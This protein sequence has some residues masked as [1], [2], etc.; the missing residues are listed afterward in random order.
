MSK[1]S[2]ILLFML[3]VLSLTKLQAQSLEQYLPQLDAEKSPAKKADLYYKIG[4]IYQQQG[5]YK[6]ALENYNN[7]LKTDANVNVIAIKQNIISSYSG[8]N[9][10]TSALRAG[11]E[12]ITYYRSRNDTEGLTRQLNE[13]A[14]YAEINR[15]QEDA[16]KY[17]LELADI[18][19]KSN[20]TDKLASIY[21]NLGVTYRRLK[22][23]QT[24]EKY[25]NQYLEILKTQSKNQTNPQ[26][27][28]QTFISIGA[29][30]LELKQYKKATPYFEQALKIAEKTNQAKLRTEAYNFKAMADF[31]NDNTTDALSNATKAKEIAEET[32]DLDNMLKSYEML[33]VIYQKQSD[34]KT[35][36]EY[37]EKIS[38]LNVAIAQ[39]RRE[40]DQRNFDRAIE[41]EKLEKE[42]KNTIAN[43]KIKEG[44]LRETKLEKE[45]AEKE[46]AIKNQQISILKKNREIETAQNRA[47]LN[48]QI[49]RERMS[50]LGRQKAEN[51][52]QKLVIENEKARADQQKAIALNERTGRE[53]KEK[54]LSLAEASAKLKDENQK[55]KDFNQLLILVGGIIIVS[56]IAIA[57]FFVYRNLRITKKLYG[58]LG[59]KNKQ[60]EGQNEEL[61]SQKEELQQNS[62]EIAAQRDAVEAINGKLDEKNTALLASI[63]Y[64]SRIQK[65]ILPTKTKLRTFFA[66]HFVLFQPR[67]IVSGDFYWFAAKEDFCM[68]SASDCTGHG[69]PGALM[70]MIA[71]SSLNKVFYEKRAYSPEKLLSGTSDEIMNALD[72]QNNQG[73]DGMDSVVCAYFPKENR[74]T[75]A[76]A[77]NSLFYVQNDEFFEIRGSKFPV[78]D[79]YYGVH[80]DFTLHEIA[81]T[82]P[83]I[84]YLLSDG[85]CDQFG[86]SEGGK[87][88]KFGK[89]QFK[90][91]IMNIYKKP[92]DVQK[93]TLQI[94]I[95]KWMV[96]GKERQIDDILVVG[97]QVN[98][99]VVTL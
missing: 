87:A 37:Q 54:E 27:Q 11:D 32:K 95:N 44:E 9:D 5:I 67:D 62:E 66:E 15:K 59:E 70:S 84:F 77:K 64:A 30:L 33:K 75:Y 76:G 10:H 98:P 29:T 63:T 31:L 7:A 53:S 79:I 82:A 8:L 55:Q 20:Q 97:F 38:K 26:N 94:T 92:M 65:G 48:E 86:A 85:F 17:N 88:Q 56:L 78:G 34:S 43:Q 28:A 68:I 41:V 13:N 69:V 50:E 42:I 58:K 46:I 74:V 18:Y 93:K 72:Q 60:I 61:Q 89:R 90:E 2:F 35:A 24:S 16:L 22:D 21:S 49:S 52:N 23:T 3:L 40:A 12:L 96:E 4:E 47:I 1:T 45:K 19:K 14:R 36:A 99:V 57:L 73:S 80:R 25:F 91:L 6:K 51:E 39:K 71:S 83:T 81:I